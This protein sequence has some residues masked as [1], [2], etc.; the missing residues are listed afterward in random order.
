[1]LRLYHY[2]IKKR[3]YVH[4]LNTELIVNQYHFPMTHLE[5]LMLK[6]DL[7]EERFDELESI[8][9][10]EWELSK[11]GPLVDRVIQFREGS[12]G[13]RIEASLNAWSLPVR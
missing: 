11:K 3:P 8:G 6:A 4:K 2:L 7:G 13:A 12:L 9:L 10:I 5:R 1:M